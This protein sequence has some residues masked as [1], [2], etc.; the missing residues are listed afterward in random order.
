MIAELLSL[1][2]SGLCFEY[3]YEIES[4]HHCDSLVVIT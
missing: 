1:T 3:G 4:D 2:G